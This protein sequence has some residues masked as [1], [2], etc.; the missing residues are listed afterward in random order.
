M[1]SILS[2][3]T[4]IRWFDGSVAEK[5]RFR[6]PQLVQTLADALSAADDKPLQSFV[7]KVAILEGDFDKLHQNVWGEDPFQ[8]WSDRWKLAD[9]SIVRTTER[10]TAAVLSSDEAR[11]LLRPPLWPVANRPAI[12]GGTLIA[13]PENLREIANVKSGTRDWRV[14]WALLCIAEARAWNALLWELAVGVDAISGANPFKCWL[15]ISA[16]GAFPM[17]QVDDCY[18]LFVVKHNNSNIGEIKGVE[19]L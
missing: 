10:L 1:N 7:Q 12:C 6:L 3:V 16:A 8:P 17:G 11:A 18:E 19:T 14:A 4:N 13:A 2:Q 9:A 15:D 5:N